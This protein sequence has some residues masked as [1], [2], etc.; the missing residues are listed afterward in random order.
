M[1][2]QVSGAVKIHKYKFNKCVQQSIS[3]RSWVALKTPWKSHV[4]MN[5][6]GDRA[7]NL[8]NQNDILTVAL[9]Q[10]EAAYKN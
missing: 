9:T 6:P 5:C 1:F 3:D 7:C 8:Q 4:E 2:K 10:L